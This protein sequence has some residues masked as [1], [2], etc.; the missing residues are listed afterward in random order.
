MTT[1][2]TWLATAT[3]GLVV[4]CDHPSPKC[5]ERIW[6]QEKHTDWLGK[7]GDLVDSHGLADQLANLEPASFYFRIWRRNLGGGR[8]SVIPRATNEVFLA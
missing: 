4:A 5:D 7:D 8:R 2:I 1:P 3:N 6:K